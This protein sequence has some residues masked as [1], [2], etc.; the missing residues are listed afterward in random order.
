MQ[1][2]EQE[3]GKGGREG[4]VEEREGGFEKMGDLCGPRRSISKIKMA[5][6]V[7]ETTAPNSLGA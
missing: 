2:E 7:A 6:V 4:G 5:V 3:G 1:K